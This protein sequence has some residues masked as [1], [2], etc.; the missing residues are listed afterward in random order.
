MIIP[1]EIKY[2]VETQNPSWND[3]IKILLEYHPVIELAYDRA[4]DVSKVPRIR[5]DKEWQFYIS[6]V[7]SVLII[8][9]RNNWL[10]IN[11]DRRGSPLFWTIDTRN[12]T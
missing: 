12:K 4:I 11:Q 10:N 6:A 8:G 7:F 1:E 2:W 5:T 9:E 3:A